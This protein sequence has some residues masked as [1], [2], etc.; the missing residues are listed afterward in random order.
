MQT[1]ILQ[2]SN[3]VDLTLLKELAERLNVSYFFAELPPNYTITEPE[4]EEIMFAEGVNANEIV[5]EMGIS[6]AET[7]DLFNQALSEPTLS[8]EEFKQAMQ[9][10]RKEQ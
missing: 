2:S 9:Q 5:P 7:L 6:A 1:L 3:T 4:T 8:F 10:W